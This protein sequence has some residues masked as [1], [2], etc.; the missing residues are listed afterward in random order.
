MRTVR[1]HRPARVGARLA[2]A[3]C[4]L[5]ALAILLTACIGDGSCTGDGSCSPD[6][7]VNLPK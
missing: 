1:I 5:F 4:T 7:D 3:I 2:L 6:V